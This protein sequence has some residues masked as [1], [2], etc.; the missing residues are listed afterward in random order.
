M[1]NSFFQALRVYKGGEG[2]LP[3]LSSMGREELSKG[4]VT[5]AVHYSSVNYKDALAVTGR[6][7]ILKSFPLNP[8]IDAAGRVVSSA[9]ANFSVGQPVLVT[10]CGLGE[11]LD[12]GLAEEIRVPAEVVIPLPQGLSLREAMIY[13]T[14]GFTAAL[15]AKRMLRNGQTPNMGPIVV[16][17]ASGGVGSFAVAMLSRLG[18]EVWA[19]SG[20]PEFYSFLRELGAKRTLALDELHLGLRPLESVQFG[21]VIDNI[22]GDFLSRVGA[23]VQLWGN[24]ACVGLAEGPYLKTTVMPLI[25]RG[26][27]LLG[28]SS[29][30]TPIDLRREIWSDISNEWRPPDLGRFVANEVGLADVPKVAIDMLNR[31]TWG[32]TLVKIR[33]EV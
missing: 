12:G 10:G 30:N 7:P 29:N 1:K 8:G 32:R 16:S 21:G 11:V 31:R 19:L 28:I 24:I 20:K 23:H 18:F 9:S 3:Q 13:G 33:D 5:I 26:V 27:S 6:G 2:P 17:G 14:A 22:G 4:E 15:C 25:L